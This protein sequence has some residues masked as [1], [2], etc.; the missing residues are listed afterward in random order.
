M[1]LDVQD[2]YW[3]KACEE[4]GGKTQKSEEASDHIVAVIQPY[5]GEREGEGERVE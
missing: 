1:R 4:K 2:I 3:E 5:E